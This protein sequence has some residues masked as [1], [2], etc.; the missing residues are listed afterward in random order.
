MNM[1]LNKAVASAT[2]LSRRKADVAIQEGDVKLNGNIQT[3]PATIIDTDIDHIKYKGK[4]IHFSKSK[5]YYMVNKPKGYLSTVSDDLNR[6]TVLSLLQK[7][8]GLFPVGR[9]DM[10][11]RGLILVTNDGEFAQNIAHPSKEVLKVYKIKTD[12]DLTNVEMEH[13]RTGK[14][15]GGGK[16]APKNFER[17]GKQKYEITLIEGAKRQIRNIFAKL[18]IEVKDLKRISIGPLKLDDL[19]EGCYRPLSVKEINGLSKK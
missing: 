10:E 2:E 17:M 19:P 4:M 15:K 7:P 13:I 1:R 8:R 14:N 11:T 16:K 3:N 12:R 6:K 18:S 5:Q 9:L